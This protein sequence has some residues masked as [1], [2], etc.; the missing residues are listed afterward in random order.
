MVY[1]NA[2]NEFLT[3]GMQ[4]VV[5]IFSAVYLNLSAG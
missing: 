1:D 3:F 2:F 5:D 4:N